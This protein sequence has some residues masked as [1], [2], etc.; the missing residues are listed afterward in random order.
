MKDRIHGKCNSCP[1]S[2]ELDNKH[3]I[4]AFMLKN[5]PTEK[6]QETKVQ[7]KINKESKM[8]LEGK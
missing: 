2:G 3:K 8:F 5:P 1:F 7:Q 6:Q 4:T